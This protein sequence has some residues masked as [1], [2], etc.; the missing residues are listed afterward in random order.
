MADAI[1]DAHSILNMPPDG[2]REAREHTADS[3]GDPVQ[4]ALS[5]FGSALRRARLAA[6]MTQHQAALATGTTQGHWSK[7]ENARGDPTLALALRMVQ[8]FNLDS[9]ESL[10]GPGASGTLMGVRRDD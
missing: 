9:I 10:F 4:Q 6:G 3:E 8:V 1:H 5:R 7:I 2:K